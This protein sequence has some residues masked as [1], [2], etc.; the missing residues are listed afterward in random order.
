MPSFKHAGAIAVAVAYLALSLAEGGF[1][2]RLQAGVA[3]VAWWLVILGLLVR[4]WPGWPPPRAAVLCGGSLFGL[5][6]L[7]GA[8]MLWADDAG[9]AFEATMQASGYLAVFA[10]VVLA[11]RRASIRGWLIGLALGI[12]AVAVIALATRLEP[13][14]LG[15]ADRDLLAELP[16]ASGR[17]SYP[18]GYW[19]A[20]AAIMAFGIALFAWFAGCGGSRIVR[21]LSC[22]GIPVAALVIYLAQSRGGALAAGVG[23][24]VL[25]IAVRGRRASILGSAAVG[26]GA[27]FVLVLLADS[28]DAVI[29]AG[30]PAL[31]EDQGLEMAVATLV[32]CAAVV[33][34]RW[35]SDRALAALDPRAAR[36]T[37]AR[38]GAAIGAAAVVA[39]VVLAASGSLDA[40]NDP[41]TY[42]GGPAGGGGPEELQGSGRSQFWSAALD[43]FAEA[44][45][46][47]VGAGNYELFW[48]ENGSI[49]AVVEHT[50]SYF[51]ENLA[52]LGL[53]GLALALA[54]F[55]VPVAAGIARDRHWPSGEVGA[56][57]AL[58]A[59]GAVVGFLEW[60]WEIPAAFLPTL[61]A[62]ALLTGPAALPTR[63]TP[64]AS[65]TL[66]RVL[67]PTEAPRERFGLGVATVVVGFVSI[68]VAGV[69][70]LTQ[71]EIEASQDAARRGDF[72]DAADDARAAATIQPWSPEPYLQ[73]ALVEELRGRAEEAQGAVDDAIERAPGDWRV[74]IVASRVA[75]LSGDAVGA[76]SAFQR[77]NGLSPIQLEAPQ[78]LPK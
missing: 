77:A 36:V 54:F 50:H 27:G 16:A 12:A 39:T 78:P 41:G 63:M 9:R 61:L 30:P 2:T 38:I 1:S 24:A 33:A 68:W 4:V 17:L 69:V 21:A 56:A 58:L 66:G 45:L 7:S 67:G 29:A 35:A 72:E 15:S 19:N 31:A 46:G 48:N 53:A 3:I 14:L 49:L 51:L 64:P 42:E 26:V 74:W 62:A 44:P 60:T 47:G 65:G 20:L 32:A 34:V 11:S 43:A 10:L 70:F 37:P 75:L 59:A 73:L 25:V 5:A 18:V 76:Y 55:A 52:E 57:L 23:L 22:A 71:L 40:F 8:S 6:A 13:G 28:R